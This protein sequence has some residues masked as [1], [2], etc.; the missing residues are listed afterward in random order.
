MPR[1]KGLPKT[2]GKKKGCKNRRTLEL[3]RIAALGITPLDYLLKIM[4]DKKQPIAFRIECAKAACVFC[5]ARRAPE[6]N[7][8]DTVPTVIYNLPDLEA[9]D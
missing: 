4:R 1:P 6:N 5:H 9:K 2:G 3:D 7:K 8:G